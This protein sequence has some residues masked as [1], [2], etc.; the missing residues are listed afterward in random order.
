MADNGDTHLGGEDLDQCARQ[1]FKKAV[2]QTGLAPGHA[3]EE[4][5][6][7]HEVVPATVQQDGP[8]LQY[9]SEELRAGHEIVLAAVRQNGDALR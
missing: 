2:P 6:A 1:H 4:L 5:R 9:A 8:V 7:D 3:S